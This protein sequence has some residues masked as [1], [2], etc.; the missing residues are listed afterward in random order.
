MKVA[1]T[2]LTAKA[3]VNLRD[4]DGRMAIN[5]SSNEDL[6]VLLQSRMQI[7]EEAVLDALIPNQELDASAEIGLTGLVST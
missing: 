5:F 6:K 1:Q 4:N 7:A 3:D 2:L